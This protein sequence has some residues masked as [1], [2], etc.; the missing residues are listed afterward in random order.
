MSLFKKIIVCL[1][2]LGVIGVG[3]AYAD[4]DM[5][6]L[7]DE[8]TEQALKTMI[9]PIFKQAGLSPDTVKFI[10]VQSNEMNAFVAGGQNIFL[11]TDLILKTDNPEELFGV[12][13][14]ETGHIADGHL[15]RGKMDMD[16]LS[17]EAILSNL[18]GV[19]V[20]IA[21][22]SPGAGTAISSA[23]DSVL[24]RTL[25]RHTRTQEGSADRAGVRFLQGAGLPVTGLLSFMKKLESQELIPETEQSEYVQTHPLTQDRVEALQHAVDEGPPGH[26]P[27]EWIELHRRLKAK[28]LGYLF[29]DRS[30]QDTG[31]APATQYGHV[32]A[33]FRKN[34]PDK[35]LAT[36][37]P[38]IKAEPNNPYFYELKGQIQYENGHI[39]DSI[40]S[41][42]RAA[43]L[44]P[45]SGLI[46]IAYAQSLLES[47]PES[48]EKQNERL[49]EAI[50]QLNAALDA[51]KQASEPHHMLAIA[52]GK[53]GQ[54]GMSRLQLAEEALLQNNA[55][56][57]RRE[58]QLARVNLKKGTPA[59]Q[60]A[61]DILDLVSQSDR[62]D[63]KSEKRD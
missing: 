9:T 36:L 63:N 61:M 33:W 20:A 29:P 18:L 57:A 39:E 42:S 46:R 14:H 4:D 40:Q 41:Y 55:A 10:I 50:R 48:H 6:I 21:G 15:F 23:S 19:A 32:V 1:V 12:I 16:H 28:L 47:K 27:P 34:Q 31:A 17:T 62:G 35:A 25:L 11:Y 43:E 51:E 13:A 54:E 53:Q 59:Y 22:R 5:S 56:F 60:R 26:T 8:E 38:L 37:D 2:L 3:R 45:F 30:L 24:T 7:R 44:A 52:Y 58:A 49:A